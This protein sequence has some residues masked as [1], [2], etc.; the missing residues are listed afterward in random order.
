[1]PKRPHRNHAPAFKARLAWAAVRNEGI[2]PALAKRFD[3][4]PA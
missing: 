1:M 3:V 4:H 2:F